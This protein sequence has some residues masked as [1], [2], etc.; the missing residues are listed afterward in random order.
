MPAYI[1]AKSATFG[2]LFL[3]TGTKAIAGRKSNLA[4]GVG[5]HYSL[6]NS[7]DWTILSD[8]DPINRSITDTSFVLSI[9]VPAYHTT[10]SNII[11]I[12]AGKDLIEELHI[13]ELDRSPTGGKN[14]I[15]NTYIFKNGYIISAHTSVV[16]GN[17][18]SQQS[19]NTIALTF[20]FEGFIQ[21]SVETQTSG[22]FS[23]IK[24]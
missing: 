6:L 19:V 8:I 22:S 1:Q 7:F 14:K 3:R 18:S 21:D 2:E 5:E 9:V 15:F 17:N 16:D 24:N 4:N 11:N 12:M 20:D 13:T 23:L 10:I